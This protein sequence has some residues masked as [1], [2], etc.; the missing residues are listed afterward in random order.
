M[1]TNSYGIVA[2]FLAFAITSVLR[3]ADDNDAKALV[4]KAIAATGGEAKLAAAKAL[5][6]KSKGKLRFGES[7]SQYTAQATLADLNHVRQEFEGEF[8]GNQVK[9]IVVLNGD[10]AWRKLGDQSRKIEGDA[11]AN[12]KRNIYLQVIGTAS[13]LPLKSDDFRVEPAGEEK[14][15]NADA[16]AI[17]VTGPDGK[18]FK[19]Y[20][21]KSSHLPIKIMAQVR[22]FG[23][24]EFAQETIYSDFKD[25]DGLKKATKVEGRRNGVTFLEG[26]LTDFKVLEAVDPEA[27][28]EP[29]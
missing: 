11:L 4:D 13:L 15:G 21:D 3:A 10:Q 20:F 8:G 25:F 23:G 6:W 14:V 24:D 12:E 16:V 22:G 28:A 26:E 29:K 7:A 17:K 18:D 1:R 2:F 27:F 9:G 5:T 19:L